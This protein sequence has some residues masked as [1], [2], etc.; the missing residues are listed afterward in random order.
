[1]WLRNDDTYNWHCI[2]LTDSSWNNS[3]H[4]SSQKCLRLL[5]KPVKK[6]PFFF[7]VKGP[8]FLSKIVALGK[9]T[10]SKQ[11]IASLCNVNISVDFYLWALTIF[12]KIFNL[13]TLLSLFGSFAIKTLLIVT[14]FIY[15]IIWSRCSRFRSIKIKVNN[16]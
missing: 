12:K 9:D 6:N 10:S 14:E 4:F 13:F 5:Y 8:Q 1:M 7:T 3:Q 11:I 15:I 16:V 2:N